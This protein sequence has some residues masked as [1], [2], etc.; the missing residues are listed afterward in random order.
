MT[1][2][3]CTCGRLKF[4]KGKNRGSRGYVGVYKV[5]KEGGPLGGKLLKTLHFPIFDLI[6]L[7]FQA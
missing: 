5:F 6:E 2:K 1:T 3:T 4:F 7:I